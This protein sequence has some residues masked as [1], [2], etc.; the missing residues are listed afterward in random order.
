[1]LFG[2]W[3][4]YEFE[5]RRRVE[6]ERRRPLLAS[7]RPRGRPSGLP[8]GDVK[9]FEYHAYQ[10]WMTLPKPGMSFPWFGLVHRSCRARM[11]S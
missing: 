9:C 2:S 10:I 6:L 5:S 1:M 11:A 4:R 8:R 3:F 7:K